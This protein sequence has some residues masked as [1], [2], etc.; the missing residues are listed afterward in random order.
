MFKRIFFE[1]RTYEDD[2]RR[3][4]SSGH[5]PK[6][7]SRTVV[8]DQVEDEQREIQKRKEGF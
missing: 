4:H 1:D 6:T 8:E 5:M 7:L 2:E 3:S